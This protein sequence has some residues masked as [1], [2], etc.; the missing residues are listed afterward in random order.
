MQRVLWLC[1]ALVSFPGIAAA[2]EPQT[3]EVIPSSTGMPVVIVP[4]VIEGELPELDRAAVHQALRRGLAAKELELIDA[5]PDNEAAERPDA[6]RVELHVVAGARTYE[7][8]LRAYRPAE[9]DAFMTA[10]GRCEICGLAELEQLVLARADALRQ[11]LTG[12][13]SPAQDT[14][15]SGRV[16]PPPAR[17]YRMGSADRPRGSA[18]RALGGVS[19]GIGLATLVSGAVLIGIDGNEIRSRCDDPAARDIDGDCRWVHRTLGGGVAMTVVGT[20]LA[21]T[22]VALLV[23]D[24]R[25]GRRSD[26]RALVAPNRVALSVSF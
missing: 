20:A 26:V 15:A 11:R 1:G 8:E 24:H 17:T 10:S 6:H 23:V 21:A 2:E 18:Q 3:R 9:P 22:G 13:L 4:D 7:V 19:L 14:T 12:E 5:T 16:R 25:R